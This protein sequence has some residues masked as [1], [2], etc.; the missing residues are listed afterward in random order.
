[1]KGCTESQLQCFYTGE[2]C[3]P[4]DIQQYLETFLVL[5]TG[6]GVLLARDGV[7]GGQRCCWTSYKAQGR[8]LQQ[9]IFQPKMSIVLRL[10]NSNPNS[11]LFGGAHH[12]VRLHYFLVYVW[13]PGVAVTWWIETVSSCLPREREQ[14]SVR[15]TWSQA[16]VLLPAVTCS[17]QHVQRFVLDKPDEG[18]GLTNAV[19]KCV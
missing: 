19:G 1:M 16:Q 18:Q 11:I 2:F 6:D 14:E 7:G 5:M 9:R 4:W 3:L 13:C 17:Q 8:P 10:K 12:S 15:E